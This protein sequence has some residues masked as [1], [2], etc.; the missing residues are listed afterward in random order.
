[1][2]LGQLEVIQEDRHACTAVGKHKALD[3]AGGQV[4]ILL[5]QLEVIQDDRHACTAV[6]KP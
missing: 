1:M 5:G 3:M 2:L 6:G 4:N